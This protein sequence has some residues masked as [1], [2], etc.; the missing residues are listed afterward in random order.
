MGRSTAFHPE[1]EPLRDN[2]SLH[3]AHDT[4]RGPFS[5]LNP[6][7][8]HYHHHQS[9]SKPAASSLDDSEDAE[10]PAAEVTGDNAETAGVAYKWTSRNN[11]K[12]RHALV[13][14][15]GRNGG[16]SKFATPPPTNSPR[17]KCTLLWLQRMAPASLRIWGEAARSGREGTAALLLVMRI[18][19]LS[20]NARL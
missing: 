15:S 17:S 10:R 5:F 16:N 6:T 3:L 20:F 2:P 8:A 1:R 14:N 7:Q 4:I 18:T 11:R 12:G 13:V 9:T 19:G